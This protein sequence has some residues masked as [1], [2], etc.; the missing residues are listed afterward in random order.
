MLPL[1]A[2]GRTN[3]SYC[4]TDIDRKYRQ[5]VAFTNSGLTV[6][7][8][9]CPR[10]CELEETHLQE[11]ENCCRGSPD[12]RAC[13]QHLAGPPPESKP[14]GLLLAGEENLGKVLISAEAGRFCPCW[15]VL[16]ANA[17]INVNCFTSILYI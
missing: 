6:G 7:E 11:I 8:W 10:S 5:L 4:Y 9:R 3:Q 17:G 12:R 2:A 13:I 15:N 16:A 1:P 14:G